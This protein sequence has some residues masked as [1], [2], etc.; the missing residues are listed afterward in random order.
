M[1]KSIEKKRMVSPSNKTNKQ[2]KCIASSSRLTRSKTNQ[3]E[4]L[5]KS[6][7][8]I[9]EQKKSESKIEKK[10]RAARYPFIV[11]QTQFIGLWKRKGTKFRF[12]SY[13]SVK[14]TEKKPTIEWSVN[15]KHS[16]C[17]N[18]ESHRKTTQFYKIEQNWNER[19]LFGE[20]EIF[21]SVAG[22]HRKNWKKNKALVYFFGDRREGYVQITEIYDF[23]KS[24]EAIK[25]FLSAKGKP[26]AYVT[27]LHEVELCIGIDRA[28]SIFNTV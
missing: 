7:S 17:K 10:N 5:L 13:H 27:G 26:R 22:T 4:V 28:H 1:A 12:T 24:F 6:K 21:L 18:R 8:K 19:S 2:K 9:V 3:S 23:K 25:S 16:S 14:Y 11:S 15:F 20:A